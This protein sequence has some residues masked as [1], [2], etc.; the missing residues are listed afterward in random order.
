MDHHP[1]TQTKPAASRSEPVSREARITD[2]MVDSR[3]LLGSDGKVL[4]VHDSMKYELRLT[5]QG[6]LILTK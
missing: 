1:T 3:A 5:R 6:K 2:G 4:I